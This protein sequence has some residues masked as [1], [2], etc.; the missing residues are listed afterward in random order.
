MYTLWS[1]GGGLDTH[2]VYGTA[3]AGFNI[4]RDDNYNITV[5]VQNN[6]TITA[7]WLDY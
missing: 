5:T 4:T 6:N 3:P 1:S 7:F 2:L